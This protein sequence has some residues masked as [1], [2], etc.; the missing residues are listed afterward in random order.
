MTEPPTKT[1]ETKAAYLR[2][3]EQLKASIERALGRKCTVTQFADALIETKR[4][5]LSAA[6]WRQYRSA[7]CYGLERHC[8]ATPELKDE[9]DVAL[10]RLRTTPPCKKVDGAARTSQ[11]K[12]KKLPVDDLVAIQYFVLAGQS[13]KRQALADYLTA[14]DLTGLRPCEWRRAQLRKSAVPGF[15]WELVVLCAKRTNGRSHG[16]SRTLRFVELDPHLVATVMRWLHVAQEAEKA[17][18]YHK[19]SKALGTLMHDCCMELF[20]RR[21]QRPTMYTPRH[22]AG[23]R[24]KAHYVKPDATPEEQELGRTIVAALL[25]HGTDET[26]T[27]HY[28][29]PG[30]AER[31]SSGLPIPV[32]DPAEVARVR[33]TFAAKL[34]A[35]A[36]RATRS[37]TDR[38][39]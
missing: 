5:H 36:S 37:P 28:A 6:T 14:A 21:K 38:R 4:P 17:G 8:V 12:S 11:Q 31:A 22:Q 23:A 33:H 16:D 24:W 25:G 20:S 10:A 2:R 26:A 13:P 15:E 19:L 18:T 39:L 3:A 34:E 35:K 30:Q 32:A 7:A 9:I 29:R 1:S 27:R